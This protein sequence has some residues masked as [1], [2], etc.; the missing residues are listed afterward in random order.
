MAYSDF[1]LKKVKQT[2]GVKLIEQENLFSQ[3]TAVAI[4]AYLKE[5]L[6]E[7]LP[8][9][10]AINTEKARSE[11]IIA[12]VLVELRKILQHKISLFSGI[13]FNVDKDKGLNGFCDF[14]IS[15]S[16]EQLILSS[17][18]IALVEAKN[19]N[20]IAGLG[21]CIAEMV[22]ANLFNQAE[23]NNT[24]TTLYGVV[25]TGTTWKFLK[26]ENNDVYIDLDEYA[27]EHVDKIM[28][29]LLMMIK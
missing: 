23:Q 12:N 28:G 13:E 21:Q 8:L 22:A 15:Q 17:P 11:L 14:I 1:D 19:E 7:N 18:V 6:A 5:T 16:S 4:S 27:I 9:A 25:T 3:I 26:L 24:I 10:R 2:L 29:I 20:I